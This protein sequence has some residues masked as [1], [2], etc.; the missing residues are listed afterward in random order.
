VSPDEA[1]TLVDEAAYDHI[2]GDSAAALEK[3]GRATSSCPGAVHAWHA[4][5]EVHLSLRRLD[6][7][8]VAADKA[9][10]LAPDDPLTV[11]TLSRIWMERGDKARAEQYGAKARIMGWKDE[12]REPPPSDAGG[13]H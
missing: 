3:L 2:C 8:L 5:A 1:Q 11:A 7:A 12:L 9:F 13:L 4:L 10:A 6:E